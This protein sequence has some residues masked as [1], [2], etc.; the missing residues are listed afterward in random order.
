MTHPT[1]VIVKTDQCGWI[2]Q[3][4][5]ARLETSPAKTQKDNAPDQQP[6]RLETAPTGSGTDAVEN[7]ATQGLHKKCDLKNISL[8]QASPLGER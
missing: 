7:P 4:D 8:P 1:T 2:D 5:T 3:R 6:A